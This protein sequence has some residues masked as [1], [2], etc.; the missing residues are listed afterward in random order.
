MTRDHT[1][2]QTRRLTSDMQTG[3]RWD[4]VVLFVMSLRV[5]CSFIHACFL[6]TALAFFVFH[7]PSPCV[8]D[9]L[10]CFDL[11]HLFILL[12]FFA[13]PFHQ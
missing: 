1:D 10:L 7:L 9:D 11:L 6:S 13:H 4:L 12:V 5:T 8:V 3:I 2:G